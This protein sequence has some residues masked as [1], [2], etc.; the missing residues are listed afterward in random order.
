MIQP[1]LGSSLAQRLRAETAEAHARLE[2]ATGFD[3][4]R[5]DAACAVQMLEDFYLVLRH[6]EPTIFSLLPKRLAER[7]RLAQLQADLHELG[8]QTGTVLRPTEIWLPSTETQALGALYVLEGSTLGGKIISKALRQM[9]DWPLRG[10]S[11]FDPYGSRT[12]AMWASFQLELSGVPD[13]RW[14]EVIEGA[15]KMFAVLEGAM[16]RE[17]AC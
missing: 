14:N 8:R 7:A 15:N 12:G 11:Y 3:I 10:T 4:H 6:A 17:P 13:D 9:L 16:T 2:S 1:T 5:P